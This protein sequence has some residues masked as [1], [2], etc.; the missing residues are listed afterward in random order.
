MDVK[1]I[2]RKTEK[3]KMKISLSD[4]RITNFVFVESKAEETERK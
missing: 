2:V 4:N 3:K 1:K